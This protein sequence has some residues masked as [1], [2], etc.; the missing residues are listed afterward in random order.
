MLIPCPHC[1]PRDLIE[2]TVQ[3]ALVRRPDPTAGLDAEST[4]ADFVAAV[5]TRDNPCGAHRELWYHG[6][7]CQS[8]LIVE[9]DTR[10][11]VVIGVRLA[12]E[13][14]T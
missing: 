2:Y 7:G 9:R 3:G 4:R 5:Y 14:A 11:H 13:V 10:T 6:Y 1:G 8:W 12:A